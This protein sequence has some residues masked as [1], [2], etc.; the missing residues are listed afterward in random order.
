[1][2]VEPGSLDALVAELIER[3]S[4]ATDLGDAC[5]VVL[6]TAGREFSLERALFV[7]PTHAGLRGAAW[8][9]EARTQSVLRQLDHSESPILELIEHA[10]PHG[11]SP[12]LRRQGSFPPL[13]FRSFV[14]FTV[15][16]ITGQTIGA[17]LIE[18]DEVDD[19][20]LRFAE[21]AARLGPLLDRIA[22]AGLLVSDRCLGQQR[23]E[24]QV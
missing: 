9:L 12:T 20:C 16:G 21:L 5:S 2:A 8:G 23:A 11:G 7:V 10:G 17:A 4:G 6:E 24:E 1:M 22:R 19:D 18:A 3:V 13:D 14:S 15:A